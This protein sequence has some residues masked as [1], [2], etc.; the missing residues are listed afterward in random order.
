MKF[1]SRF[2]LILTVLFLAGA[3]AGAAKADTLLYFDLTGPTNATFELY[4]HPVI[5]PGN[6]DPGYGF[7]VTPID[8]KING[9]ASNDFLTFY[10]G[11]PDAGGGLGIFFD[12]FE[13]VVSLTGAQIYSGR[14]WAPAFAPTLVSMTMTD[15]DGGDGQY[16]LSISKVAKTAEPS[17]L[18]LLSM[19]LLLP[20]GLGLSRLR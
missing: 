12:D 6:F 20:L 4:A 18:A 14:E 8:L 16:S 9:V 17:S 19:A 2:T 5:S 7:V 10:N 1:F 13:F 3:G 11:S 15:F